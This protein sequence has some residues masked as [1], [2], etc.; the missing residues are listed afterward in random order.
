VEVHLSLPEE[1]ECHSDTAAEKA[2]RA[3]LP[4][5][6]SVPLHAEENLKMAK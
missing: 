5:A 1:V 6:P 2:D 4:Y 3:A